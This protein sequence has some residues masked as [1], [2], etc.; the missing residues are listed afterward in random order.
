MQKKEGL[1]IALIS[2]SFPPNQEAGIAR[3]SWMM[4]LGLSK[5]GHKIHV[6]T[7]AQ[8]EP[9][10]RYE[11][12]YWIHAIHKDQT[13]AAAKLAAQKSVPAGLAGWCVA[14]SQQ[15]E[16]LKGFG[17]DVVSFPIWDVEGMMLLDKQNDIGVVMSLHTSYAMAKP[18]KPEWSIRP[19]FEHFHVNKVIAAETLL[20]KEV[21]YILANSQAIIDDLTRHYD[22]N[23]I[24]RT[25]LTPHG[26]FDPLSE[27]K[28]TNDSLFKQKIKKSSGKSGGLKILYV[29]RFELRK[30]FDIAC[31]AF[32]K[33]LNECEHIQ[34]SLIGDTLHEEAMQILTESNLTDLLQD[35]RV[36]FHG[37][38]TREELDSAYINNDV[39]LMPSRYE[40][41]GLVAI[42][43][44]AASTPV[45]ALAN[46]G[47]QEVI[48]HGKT[49]FLVEGS[50][51]EIQQIVQHLIY[52]A[53]NPEQLTLMKNNAREAFLKKFTIDQ[54]VESAE[55]IYLSAAG[56]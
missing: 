34:I 37:M 29:G 23:F 43:A 15:V 10:T 21:K 8:S 48:E 2:Q 49:G 6:I 28:A 42:E 3:W 53:N 13:E 31:A 55:K 33:I 38:L 19:L 46:G 51:N 54:M 56:K 52:L 4:A 35:E 22:V 40:S 45:I 50:V 7:L 24:D 44:M 17:L 1:T 32:M 9:F 39:V 5:R 12:G 20:L 16:K 18:F 27:K 30:G 26:T 11:N 41:F 36:N 47:L 25:V 14:V